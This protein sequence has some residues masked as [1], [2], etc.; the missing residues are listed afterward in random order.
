MQVNITGDLTEG[1]QAYAQTQGDLQQALKEH[2]CAIWKFPLTDTGD[3]T[4]KLD[5]DE[6]NGHAN[7]DDDD[8]D[9]PV[10]DDLEGSGGVD[11]DDNDEEME[12]PG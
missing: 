8:D 11:I 9:L 4:S 6:D 3:D 7:N 1:L 5:G 2:F 10:G 12:E